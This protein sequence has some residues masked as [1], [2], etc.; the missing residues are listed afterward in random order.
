MWSTFLVYLKLTEVFNIN[1]R[2]WSLEKFPNISVNF[3]GKIMVDHILEIPKL[4]VF[5]VKCYTTK[6][7]L[8]MEQR[9]FRSRHLISIFIGTW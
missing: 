4:A 8:Q 6:Y 2:I 3:K 1:T 7:C 5:E 9:R